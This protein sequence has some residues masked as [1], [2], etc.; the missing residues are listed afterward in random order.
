MPTVVL[1]VDLVA[2]SQIRIR[3][4]QGYRK[5]LPFRCRSG[6]SGGRDV[7]G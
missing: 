7:P 2:P 3:I 1:G 4:H 6:H 5:V